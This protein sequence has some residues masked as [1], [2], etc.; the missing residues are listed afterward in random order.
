MNAYAWGRRQLISSVGGGCLVEA[1]ALHDRRD[2]ID[3][4]LACPAWI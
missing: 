3:T 1:A 2:A 4:E